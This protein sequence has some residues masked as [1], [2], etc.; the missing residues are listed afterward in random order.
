M[1]G[2][3]VFA[4]LDLIKGYQKLCLTKEYRGATAFL[5]LKG[6]FQMKVLLIGTKTSGAVFQRLKDQML[7]NLQP[8]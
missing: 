2:S 4:T 3:L 1:S 6:S 8:H 7:R 5:S